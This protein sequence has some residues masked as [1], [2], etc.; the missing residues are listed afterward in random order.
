MSS[1]IDG[2]IAALRVALNEAESS[3]E[4]WW[5]VRA[6]NPWINHLPGAWMGR[7]WHLK[8]WAEIGEGLIS[9][10]RFI[11]HVRATLAY[12]EAN[13]EEIRSTRRWSWPLWR[14]AK[15]LHSGQVGAEFKIISEADGKGG[16]S[17]PRLTKH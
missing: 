5:K 12:L 7:W 15:T 1:K 14:R 2:V 9:R 4:H 8:L 11:G 10:A 6:A 3:H 13:R 17:Q 16:L